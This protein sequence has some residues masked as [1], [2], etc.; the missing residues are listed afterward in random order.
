MLLWSQEGNMTKWTIKKI[1]YNYN[2]KKKNV[3]LCKSN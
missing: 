1:S 3:A 2:K